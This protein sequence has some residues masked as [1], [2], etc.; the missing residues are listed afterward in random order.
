MI[1][2][3]E[4]MQKEKIEEI[5][6]KYKLINLDNK[7]YMEKIIYNLGK[8]DRGECIYPCDDIYWPFRVN[9]DLV[10]AV[11]DTLEKENILKKHVFLRCCRCGRERI[12][13]TYLIKNEEVIC[14]ECGADNDDKSCIIAYE[15]L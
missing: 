15:V 7:L 2:K 8:F 12:I 9:K 4:Y 13:N 11:L 10:Y 3:E 14:E 6:N 1:E 5:L